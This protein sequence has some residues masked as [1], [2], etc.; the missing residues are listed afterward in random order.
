MSKIYKTNMT[1]GVCPDWTRLDVA[2][3]YLANALDNDNPHEVAY[4]DNTLYITSKDTKLHPRLFALGASTNRNNPNANGT[5][6]DGSKV[7]LV[8]G[9]REGLDIKFYNSGVEWT[10]MFE[11]SDGFQEEIL[12]IEETDMQSHGAMNDFVVCINGYTEEEIATITE[13]CLYIQ[14]PSTFGKVLECEM[15]RVFFDKRGKL[16]VGGIWVTNTDLQYS[17]D[18][19]PKYLHLNRDRKTVENWDLK[20]NVAKML[21]LVETPQFI[22]KLVESDTADVG[23][24]PY[25]PVTDSVKEECFKLYEAKYKGKLLVESQSE[26]NMKV[27]EG[28]SNVIVEEDTFVKIVKSSSEY[29]SIIF[30]RNQESPIDFIQKLLDN[31]S[32]GGA[33][34]LVGNTLKLILD[35]FNQRGVRWGRG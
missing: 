28:Y 13:R 11:Y 33:S 5:H 12:V 17:Y 18:F 32:I 27:S 22:A 6:G 35:E 15:G 10:P 30:E 2:R 1:K 23:Y 21:Q 20:T 26:L 7:S 25:V 29:K 8:V 16:F 9:L 4:E 14:D 34:D 19:H 3:E 24:L 31:E